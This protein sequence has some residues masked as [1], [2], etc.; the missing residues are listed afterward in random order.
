VANFSKFCRP[1]CQIMRLTVANFQHT[2]INLLWPQNPTKYAVLFQIS[3]AHYPVTARVYFTA[4]SCLH[5][6]INYLWPP[7]ADQNMPCLS[8]YH[9]AVSNSAKFR[10]NIQILRKRANFV[11]RLKNSAFRGKLWSLPIISNER[12]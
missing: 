11:A 6:L 2:A 5:V 3:S 10:E 12:C 7:E 8:T 4:Q 1:V 9:Q